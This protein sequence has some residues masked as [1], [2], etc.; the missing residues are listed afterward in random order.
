MPMTAAC[1]RALALA[2]LTAVLIAP[3]GRS[4]PAQA[5]VA[6]AK[7]GSLPDRLT[8]A[9]FWKLLNDVSEP[10]GVFSM[11]DNFVSN[12]GQI[13]VLAGRIRDGGPHG[14]VYMGVGPEQN[15]TYITAVRPAM[16]FIVDIRRQAVM[17]HRL[18]KAIFEVAKDP[19]DFISV[20]FAKPRPGGVDSTTRIDSVWAAFEPVPTDTALGRVT[21]ERLTALMTRTHGFAFT[22]EEQMYFDHVYRS[23]VTFG[24]AITT[25]GPATGVR[26]AIPRVTTDSGLTFVRGGATAAASGAVV[27]TS[28]VV[29][30]APPGRTITIPSGAVATPGVTGAPTPAFTSLRTMPTVA[31]FAWLTQVRDERGQFDAFLGSWEAF[32]FLKDLHARNLFVV[33]RRRSARWPTTSSSTAR[34]CPRSMCPTSSPTSF[35][36][37]WRPP[38]TRTWRRC[39]PT[40]PASSSGLVARASPRPRPRRRSV[41]SADSWLPLR[42]AQ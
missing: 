18:Y 34:P 22:R 2:C 17:H 25:S 15:L 29:I 21:L 3:A 1:R 36:T 10:G 9:E 28:G 26:F 6:A 13:G 19:A 39:R 31:N 12:E 37:G 40:R 42:A 8:D 11:A 33:E 23:F 7:R 20:L 32:R 41:P 24:P 5:T 14:G 16:V 38:S 30:T 35:A 27:T 4:L